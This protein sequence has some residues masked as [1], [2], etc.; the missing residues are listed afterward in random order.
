M[1]PSDYPLPSYAGYCWFAR[2]KFFLARSGHGT[3]Y[4]EDSPDGLAELRVALLNCADQRELLGVGSGL[5]SSSNLAS[6]P[7]R[8]RQTVKGK[9]EAGNC[10]PLGRLREGA[11]S[12]N[13][14]FVGALLGSLGFWCVLFWLVL[15]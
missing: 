1:R 7:A 4:F 3:V 5:G 14:I 13:M 2:G 8:V 6:M 10:G 9:T 15:L 12:M 11:T